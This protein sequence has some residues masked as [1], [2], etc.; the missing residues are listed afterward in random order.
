MTTLIDR[1]YDHDRWASLALLDTC[2][3]L[4][5]ERLRLTTPGTYGTIHATLEHLVGARE[6]Y[7][8]VLETGAFP[9][10]PPQGPPATVAELRERIARTCDGLAAV[11]G[12][13]HAGRVIE[14]VRNGE[15]FRLG[16]W[17]YDDALAAE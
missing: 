6:R 17:A 15:P 14:G 11:A 2:A 16:A 9:P 1:I 4:A 3:A 12:S 10:R 5:P 8:A 7:L 13:G